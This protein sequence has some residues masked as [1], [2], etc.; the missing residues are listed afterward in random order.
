[1]S[2]P[3]E[4][5]R[6]L[7]ALAAEPASADLRKQLHYLLSRLRKGI[8]AKQFL[9]DDRLSVWLPV[10]MSSEQSSNLENRYSQWLAQIVNEKMRRRGLMATFT[11][12]ALLMLSALL[13]IVAMCVF[14]VPTFQRMY[15][16]FGLRLPP[17]TYLLF[18]VAD[19]VNYRAPFL[20]LGLLA[21][22][23]LIVLL[24]KVWV[25]Q[26]FTTRAFGWLYAGNNISLI[27]MSRL[28]SVLAELL[29]LGAPLSDALAVAGRSSRHAYYRQAAQQ[30]AVHVV[31][32]QFGWQASPVAHNF[33]RTLLHALSA[34]KNEQANV[35][36][37]RE[38]S[39][40]YSERVSARVSR[41]TGIARPIVVVSVGLLVAFVVVA[42]FM[43]LVQMVTALS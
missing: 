26:A 2:E 43:P 33:P 7:E 1:M 16:E 18:T 12:P 10:I 8:N 42:L 6:L 9:N 31:D 34:G 35:P 32:S 36:L 38:L 30:L 22:I 4:L 14:I 13:I 23:G 27:A 11:Y 20:L 40:I 41:G 39:R 21:A 5:I 17:P 25:T 3:V 19:L 15:A 28:T 24:R 37:I 29:D